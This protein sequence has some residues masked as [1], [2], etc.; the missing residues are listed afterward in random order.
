MPHIGNMGEDNHQ[1]WNSQLLV[2]PGVFYLDLH[3]D[4]ASS[5]H[6]LFCGGAVVESVIIVSFPG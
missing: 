4:F 5:N 3:V 6:A 1:R 2:V